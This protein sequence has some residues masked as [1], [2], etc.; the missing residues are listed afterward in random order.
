MNKDITVNLTLDGHSIGCVKAAN[1]LKIGLT[2]IKVS[3]G[4]HDIFISTTDNLPKLLIDN[5]TVNGI[6][7]IKFVGQI[8]QDSSLELLVNT[9]AFKMTELGK[10]LLF[11]NNS[12]EAPARANRF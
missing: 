3:S 6:L 8:E 5:Q 12:C 1:D 7:Q 9:Q 11:E 2:T 4:N 10:K